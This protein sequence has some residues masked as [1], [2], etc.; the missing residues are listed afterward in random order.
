[1]YRNPGIYNPYLTLT[2]ET[3]CIVQINAPQNVTVLGSTPFFSVDKH[4]FC[5]SSVIA[6]T[7]FTISNDGLATETFNFGDG[8]PAET[9]NPGTGNFDP[10]HDYT[11]SG[12]WT[13]TLQVVTNS[14]CTET[15]TDTIHAYQTPHPV[16]S[17]PNITCIGLI[18]F[19]GSITAPQ[20][21]SISYNWTF[22]N[23][24]TSQTQDPTVRMAPGTYTV[25]LRTSVSFGCTDT[26]SAPV[27]VHPLPLIHGPHEITTPVGIPVTIPFTYSPGVVSYTWTPADNLD[28]P[29]CANP[30]TTIVFA[31]T[32]AVTATDSNN[33]SASD[34][35]LIKT[36]C[37]DKNYWFPN[38]FSP[39]GDGVNDYFFPRGTSLY[40][41]QSL[42]IFNRWGQMVFQRRDFPANVQNLG[43][44]GAYAGKPAPADA[45][46]YMAQVVCENAQ[47]V[48]LSGNVTLIR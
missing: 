23:G 31:R 39:N 12:L 18:Q 47:V 36:I 10:S 42:T 27:T 41:I 7:D 4:A 35:I 32:Y 28:C 34:T 15:Y 33:C 2:D 11:R 5:D 46:V 16:I 44:D 24:Q 30:V 1:M 6:F 26:S 40:N 25:A 14:A 8:S 43:W 38:T 3:G 9:L 29:T 22:G 17:I 19:Q 20:T 37:N 48:L 45:Y 13:A 21:D